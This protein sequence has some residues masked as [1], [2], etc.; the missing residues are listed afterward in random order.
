[1]KNPTT[2]KMADVIFEAMVNISK[3]SVE[4]QNLMAEMEKEVERLDRALDT[5]EVL[6]KLRCINMRP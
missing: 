4:H 1:M 5:A 3:K 6:A 2:N